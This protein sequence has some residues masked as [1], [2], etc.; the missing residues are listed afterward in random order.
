MLIT[1][2]SWELA[3][4]YHTPKVQV[5]VSLTTQDMTAQSSDQELVLFFKS[6]EETS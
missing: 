2:G 4:Y 5:S 1:M 3:L 6:Q